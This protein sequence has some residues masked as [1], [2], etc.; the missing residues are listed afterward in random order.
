MIS[1][2]CP[3]LSSLLFHDL[4]HDLPTMPVAL[5]THRSWSLS[6]SPCHTHGS[7]HS[8][9]MI[10]LLGSWPLSWSPYHAHGS[11]HSSLMI[12]FMISLP[13][14]WLSSFISHDL[15][16]RFMTSFMISLP[17][18]WLSS[19]ISHDLSAR[20]MISLSIFPLGSWF[21]CHAHDLS[22]IHHPLPQ[23]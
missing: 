17:C 23:E 18:P 7:H 2:P 13:C 10:F 11:H 22:A 6:W 14:P 20:F 5:I 1:L 15:S 8:S 12:S 21:P 16:A 9:L 3:W 4:S 19:L